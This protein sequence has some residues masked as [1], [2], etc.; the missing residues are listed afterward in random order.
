MSQQD[1]KIMTEDR[2][3]AGPPDALMRWRRGENAFLFERASGQT[4]RL[5]VLADGLARVRLAPAGAFAESLTERWGFVRAD[6]PPV[7]AS[8]AEDAEAIRISTAAWTIRVT[9]ASLRLA[10]EDGAGR[11]I[12]RERAPATAGPASEPTL[13]FDMPA[14]ERFYGF[15]FQRLALDA[16]GHRLLWARRFRHKEATV[17]FFMSTRGY[18][19]YSNNT[20]EHTF[21]AGERPARDAA[22]FVKMEVLDGRGRVIRQ[23]EQIAQ[24]GRAEFLGEEYV[25][26]ETV[27]RFTSPGVAPSEVTIRPAPAVPGRMLGPPAAA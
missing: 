7:A 9:R 4:L 14:D 24:R 10:W 11:P 15:G 26:G 19:F 3:I 5:D 1:N 2:E 6:W 23:A 13:A 21:D 22:G 20:W 18:G 8:V 25:P 27:F 12:L 16:R 17:P